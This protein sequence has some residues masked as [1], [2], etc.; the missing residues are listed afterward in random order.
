MPIGTTGQLKQ[1]VGRRKN[2]VN[3]ECKKRRKESKIGKERLRLSGK[4]K[5]N[6]SQVQVR[7]IAACQFFISAQKGSW[8]FHGNLRSLH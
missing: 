3:V 5:D 4:R 1:L 7:D 8:T 6:S 2:G